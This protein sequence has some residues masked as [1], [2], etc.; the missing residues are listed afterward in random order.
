MLG[1]DDAQP[2]QASRASIETVS[3]L[4]IIGYNAVS[5][6][7]QQSPRKDHKPIAS[8]RAMET[9]RDALVPRRGPAPR[10]SPRHHLTYGLLASPFLTARGQNEPGRGRAARPTRVPPPECALPD[11]GDAQPQSAGIGSGERGVAG[12]NRLPPIP[13]C[14]GRRAYW[15]VTVW[16]QEAPQVAALFRSEIGTQFGS[17]QSTLPFV[18]P[19]AFG[20][21]YLKRKFAPP[22]VFVLAL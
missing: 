14:K 5:A 20:S 11:A 8:A 6:W 19:F 16:L 17:A 1:E 2:C 10:G 21:R 3:W 9:L 7:R 18:P 12:V 13:I 15:Q 4:R 22:W